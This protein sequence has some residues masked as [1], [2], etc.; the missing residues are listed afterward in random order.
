MFCSAAWCGCCRYWVSAPFCT[1]KRVARATLVGLVFVAGLNGCGSSRKIADSGT[2]AGGGGTTPIVI[3]PSGTYN[4]LVSANCR[5][6]YAL[7]SIDLDREVSARS[8]GR[9]YPEMT[10]LLPTLLQPGIKPEVTEEGAR[11]QWQ[12][13]KASRGRL[14]RGHG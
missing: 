11:S 6:R 3:T 2:G 9:P 10:E 13:T 1:R 5:R 8:G 4:I 14:A 7:G 12:M